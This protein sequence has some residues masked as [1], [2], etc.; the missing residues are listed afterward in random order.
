STRPLIIGPGTSPVASKT[1]AKGFWRNRLRRLGVLA[2]S[3]LAVGG[4]TIG[5]LRPGHTATC[6]AFRH[7]E[8]LELGGWKEIS[9]TVGYPAGMNKPGRAPKKGPRSI[10]RRGDL[11]ALWL[12]FFNHL[13]NPIRRRA[14]KF[15]KALRPRR[16]I[17]KRGPSVRDP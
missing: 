6:S 14:A 10:R 11:L 9:I 7:G 1:V 16:D 13:D 2:E 8:P 3:A 4:G 17:S 5:G 12:H 15:R